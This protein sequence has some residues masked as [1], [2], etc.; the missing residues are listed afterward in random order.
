M[1]KHFIF[2]LFLIFSFVVTN[3]SSRNE[4]TFLND[5]EKSSMMRDI[6]GSFSGANTYTI[7]QAINLKNTDVVLVY[8]NVNSNT[9]VLADWRIIPKDQFSLNGKNLNYDFALSPSNIEIYTEANF[10]QGTLTSEEV[11]TYLSNQRFRLILIPASTA[12]KIQ[13]D[14]SDYN[15]V[16]K[17]FDIPDRPQGL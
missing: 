16:I 14:L 7:N 8:R 12:K 10:D 1:K 15:S 6:T 11:S 4:D 13:I 5:N 17:Y 3:C 9:A 2:L